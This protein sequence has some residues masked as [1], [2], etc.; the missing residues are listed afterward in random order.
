[1][2]S[3][4]YLVQPIKN[5]TRNAFTLFL[6]GLMCMAFTAQGKAQYNPDRMLFTAKLLLQNKEATEA[7]PILNRIIAVYPENTEAFYLRGL[8]KYFLNDFTG[9]EEDFSKSI[10]IKRFNP[11]AF[12]F[13]GISRDMMLNF[14]GAVE[15]FETALE[16]RPNDP[17]ILTDLS[18]SLLHSKQA[19]KAEKTAKKALKLQPNNPRTLL[20]LGAISMELDS[21]ANAVYYFTAVIERDPN[22]L[23]A[24]TNRAKAYVALENVEKAKQDFSYVLTKNPEHAMARLL[25]S[26]LYYDNLETQFALADLDT[27]LG[28][29]PENSNA[30]YRRALLL[31]ETN[32]AKE[33]LQSLNTLIGLNPDNFLAYYTRASVLFSLKQAKAAVTD[34]QMT[35]KLY[36]EFAD[37]WHNLSIVLERGGNLKEAN[38]AKAMAEALFNQSDAQK[39]Y[40]ENTFAK[41]APFKSD[42]NK[43]SANPGSGIEPMQPK[44]VA[45]AFKELQLNATENLKIRSIAQSLNLNLTLASLQEASK[46][47]SEILYITIAEK[48][49]E[50]SSGNTSAKNY[51]IRGAAYAQTKS[52]NLAA[53]DFKKALVLDST[54]TIARINL[55]VLE[56]ERLNL[57]TG[58]DELNAYI[59]PNNYKQLNYNENFIQAELLSIINEFSKVLEQDR[60]LA[61][62]WY[63]RAFV[64]TLLKDYNGAINDYEISLLYRENFPEALLNSGLIYIFFNNPKI[65]CLNF[66]KAGELGYKNAY[67]IISRFCN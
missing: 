31:Y 53:E 57:R 34:Y 64:K 62:V 27:L 17:D 39:K 47:D 23:Q 18:I 11:D 55:A 15:D 40:Q 52:L 60:N 51:F 14:K 20:C 48:T 6:V 61:F 38:Q 10:E 3:P 24:Y 8:A 30:L 45:L 44:F 37:A 54:F 22:L 67:S 46:Y 42:F 43:A 25:R 5:I 32:R 7:M 4:L 33:A 1:M 26:E 12:H 63:N 65:A 35:L 21:A 49:A 13:R 41:L 66:S 29:N 59:N 16:Q 19:E 56:L 28:F 2:S 36:P 58:F 50:I 9:A